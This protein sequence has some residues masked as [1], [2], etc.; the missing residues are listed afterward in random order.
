MYVE[1]I[2]T[3]YNRPLCYVARGDMC[4]VSCETKNAEHVGMVDRV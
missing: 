4:L 1:F 2:K 3:I